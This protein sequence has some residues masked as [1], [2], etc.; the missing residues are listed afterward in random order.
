MGC[1][2]LQK[3][4]KLE[5]KAAQQEE[6]SLVLKLLMF[7]CKIRANRQALL[8]LGALSLLLEAARRAFS[9]DAAEPAEGL[10]LIVESLVSEAN[11]SDLRVSDSFAS[12]SSAG[13]EEGT[14]VQAASA[15]H[16]FLEKLSHPTAVTKSNKQQRN[17]ETVARILP[18]LTYGEEAA[19]EVLIDHFIPYLQDW[20]AFDQLMKQHHDNT[21][22]DA[23]AQRAAQQQLA[24]E[25]F[26]R[27]TESIKLNPNGERLKSLIME[28][29]ITT[30]EA[31]V[32]VTE[33]LSLSVCSVFC[34]K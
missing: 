32:P 24:L 21:N 13:G 28:R 9:T 5:M 22:D 2:G 25:N 11:D 26:V 34:S 19:M 18:Y 29:G 10:L 8:Q 20:T 17:N 31:L 7:C 6:L 30:G 1:V 27:V 4:S 12:S 14:G 3:L 23:I 15:V 33:C 16:M